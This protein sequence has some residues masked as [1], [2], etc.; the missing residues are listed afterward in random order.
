LLANDTLAHL[1]PMTFFRGLVLDLD[2]EQRDSFDIDTTALSP[3]A[4]AARVFALGGGRTGAPNTLFRLEGAA[5]DYPQHAAVFHDAGEAFR[6]AIYFRALAGSPEI[7]ARTLQK[8][9][10]LILKRALSSIHRLLE[11]T[12]AVFF[13]GLD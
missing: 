10:Q 12:Q 2:G 11:V 4:D 3:I 5:H 7:H 8:T 9:E 1:P 6:T 13:P